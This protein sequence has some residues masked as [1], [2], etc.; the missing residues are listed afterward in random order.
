MQEIN[1]K[2]DSLD[3]YLRKIWQNRFILIVFVKRDL[4]IKYAQTLLGVA[5]TLVYPA[6]AILIYTVFFSYILHIES[7]YP[8]VLFVLSGVICWGIFSFVFNQAGTALHHSGEMA[9]KMQFPKILIPL[10]KS[11][12]ALVEFIF[13]FLLFILL[14]LIFKMP[15]SLKWM[16]FPLA[17]I[18]VFFAAL[19]V[20]LLMSAGSLKKR[21]LLN[22]IPFIVNFSI[23]F[24]PVFYPVSI[25]PNHFHFL[26]N[27]NPITSSINLFR[28][29]FFNE[30]LDVYSYLG[31]GF[32]LVLFVLGLI[33]FKSIEEKINDTL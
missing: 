2:P 20:A 11:I 15:F 18:P 5:W 14:I 21:D 26:L 8:Y 19:G 7:K 9:R 16:L 25:I 6:T 4:K 13:S 3:V 30:P 17:I 24:T 32:S 22:I 29:F 1:S 31:F 10:S 23:W 28:N 33:S 27:M 12:L